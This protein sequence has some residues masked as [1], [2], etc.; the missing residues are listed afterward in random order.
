VFSLELGDAAATDAID[1]VCHMRVDT[2]HAAGRLRLDDTEFWFCSLH[3]AALFAAMPRSY[4][5]GKTLD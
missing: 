3:C 2:R 4:I 1:P 5:Q